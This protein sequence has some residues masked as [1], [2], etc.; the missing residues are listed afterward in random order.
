[1][2]T[3]LKPCPFCGGEGAGTKWHHGYWS[4]QCGYYCDARRSDLCFQDWGEFDTEQEAI[5]AWN[6]RSNKSVVETI[7]KRLHGL[8][9]EST[10]GFYGEYARVVDLD[11]VDD[12]IDEFSEEAELLEEPS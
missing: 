3:E 6:R 7:R 10:E 2:N 9:Y 11:E 5:D 1:M 4:V 12:L 8:S